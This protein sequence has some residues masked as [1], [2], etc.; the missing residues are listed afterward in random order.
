MR[1]EAT[2]FVGFTCWFKTL[3]ELLETIWGV[4]RVTTTGSC[5]A[6]EGKEH[7]EHSHTCIEYAGRM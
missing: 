7:Q 3:K 2:V 4:F 6:G 5:E 1:V